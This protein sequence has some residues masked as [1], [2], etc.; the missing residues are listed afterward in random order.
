MRRVAAVLALLWG[1][2]NLLAAYLMVTSA[3]LSKT[4]AKEGILSQASLLIGGL[5][6]A[7]FALAL[8]RQCLRMVRGPSLAAPPR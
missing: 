8:L 3:F 1:L 7:Y 4:S 5:A 2:A 6:L